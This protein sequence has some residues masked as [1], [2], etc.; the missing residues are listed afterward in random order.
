MA[1]TPEGAAA[2]WD[3]HTWF[4]RVTDG[5]T[6]ATTEATA[7]IDGGKLTLEG[8]FGTGEANFEW[9]QRSVAL[10]PNSGSDITVDREDVD[11]GR[12][13]E[14]SIWTLVATV[15]LMTGA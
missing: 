8:E 14:G 11:L 6:T 5:T 1:L 15:E 10:A 4:L 13:V 9:K 2:L 3:G 7:T 12:K